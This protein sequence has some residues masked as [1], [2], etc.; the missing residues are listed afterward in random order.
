MET[1]GSSRFR[2]RGVVTTLVVGLGIVA[3][4]GMAF[5]W[6]RNKKDDSTLR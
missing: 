1:N 6:G 4:L 2:G 3:V 5:G